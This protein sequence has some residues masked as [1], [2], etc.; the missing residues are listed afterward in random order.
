ALDAKETAL[1]AAESQA[2]LAR[3]Q[4]AYAHLTADAPGVI[5]AVLAEPGQVVAAGQAIVK[6]ARDGEREAVIALP[7]NGV[8][9]LAPGAEAEVTLWAGKRAYKGRLRELSPAADPATRTYAAR[10][11]LLDADAD[12]ALGMTANVRFSRPG[13][14]ALSLPLSA[15][16][17][18]DGKGA[19]PAVW[20]VGADNVLSLRPVTVGAYTDGGASVTAGLQPGERVVVAGVHKLAAGQ[21]VRLGE[22]GR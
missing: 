10:V 18:Q 4:S 2:G 5:A 13:P 20:V 6:L 16:F 15:V 8:A 7:E 11:S 22:T 21:A 14:A 9:G 19:G 12:A 3:N 17:Q 1:K